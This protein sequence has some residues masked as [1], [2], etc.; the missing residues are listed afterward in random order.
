MPMLRILLISALTACL[1]TSCVVHKSVTP[2]E[3]SVM[4]RLVA[5]NKRFT[6]GHAK[7]P[8]ATPSRIREL[9]HEQH[10][11]AVVISCSDSRVPPE[12][13]FDQG[14]G[15]LFTIRTAGNVIGE[16]ELGSIEY[17]VAQLGCRFILVMGHEHCGAIKAYLEQEDHPHND[18]IQHIIQYI[19]DEPEEQQLPDSLRTNIDQ[20]VNANILHGVNLLKSSEPVLKTLYETGALTIA[21][22]RYDLDSGKV[23]FFKQ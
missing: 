18:H 13:I 11:F 14:L 21:G 5:G 4:E 22:A 19:A 23:E 7:H 2:S 15:D 1:M 6:E 3:Q 8:H 9:S 20:A 16:Y 10:P 17:A 12:L